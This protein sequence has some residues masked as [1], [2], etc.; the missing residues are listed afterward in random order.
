MVKIKRRRA[1]TSKTEQIHRQ[2]YII[3]FLTGTF[4]LFLFTFGTKGLLSL[5]YLLGRK[6]SPPPSSQKQL[7]LLPPRLFPLPVATNSAEITIRG[8]GEKKSKIEIFLN[9]KLL[10]FTFADANGQFTFSDLK[11]KEG[12]NQIYAVCKK[13]TRTSLPS[14]SLSITF[15]SKPPKLVI[16]SPSPNTTVSE[17]KLKIE[18]KTDPDVSLFINGKWVIVKNDG[19]F[20]FELPLSEGENKIEVI[21]QDIGGNETKKE[22]SVTYKP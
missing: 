22:F 12:E 14:N 1:S 20:S 10:G 21:A 17:E 7:P 13:E 8:I 2:L 19:S 15:K 4:L 5:A 18:G 6:E 3:L 11:L 16:I 9:N